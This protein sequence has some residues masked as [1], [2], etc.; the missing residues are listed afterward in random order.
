M[1]NTVKLALLCSH[2]QHAIWLTFDSVG[3][4]ALPGNYL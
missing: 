4:T 1:H 2:T 3:T